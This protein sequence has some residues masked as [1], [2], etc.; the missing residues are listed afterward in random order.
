M[1]RIEQETPLLPFVIAQRVVD[2]WLDWLERT[3]G[4]GFANKIWKRHEAI[5]AYLEQRAEYHY[6]NDKQFSRKLH[7]PGDECLDILYAFMYHWM[8]AQMIASFPQL[9]GTVPAS[10]N[11]TSGV[12]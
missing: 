8:T 2:D 12:V 4:P 6:A 5:E 1:G 7:V 10:I 3:Q 11:G 9:R